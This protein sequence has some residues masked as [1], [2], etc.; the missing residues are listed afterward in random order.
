MKKRSGFAFK[1]KLILL[2]LL[3]LTLPLNGQSLAAGISPQTGR[4]EGT[5]KDETIFVNLSGA[6]GIKEVYVINA[7]PRPNGEIVDFG[8][9]AALVNLTNDLKPQIEGERIT[10]KAGGENGIF[11][12]QGRLIGRKLPWI[13]GFTYYLDGRRL[14]PQDLAG[15]SGRLRMEIGVRANPEADQYFREQFMVQISIP[16]EM[17]K[18]GSIYAPEAV[19]VVAGNLTT[20][21]FTLLPGEEGIFVVEADVERFEMGGIEIAAM[22]AE[23]T[24]GQIGRDLESG[25]ADMAEGMEELIEGTE[26]LQEGMVDFSDGAGRLYGAVA[27]INENSPALLAGIGSFETGLTDLATGLQELKAGFDGFRSV[28][29][30][31]AAMLEKEKKEKLK[32]LSQYL[33]E[34]PDP[35]VQELAD[36][37]LAQIA[38]LEEIQAGIEGSNGGL[39]ALE[40]TVTGAEGLLGSFT[41]LSTGLR[42]LLTGMGGISEGAGTMSESAAVLPA[43]VQKLIDGQKEM[44]EGIIEAKGEIDEL[45]EGEEAQ[46]V[47]F[48]SPGRANA[49]SVQFVMRTPPVKIPEQPISPDGYQEADKNVWQRFQDLF[50]GRFTLS[51]D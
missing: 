49:Q 11:R 45:T 8:D 39:A 47:S 6:G 34:N 19:R 16:L 41:G 33:L 29:I 13:F 7:F 48:V 30:G 36:A 38:A 46:T 50:R 27:K 51:R 40:K 12:Y 35:E 24:L 18:S 17:D 4:S 5:L 9:Y 25:F 1:V 15:A 26:K 14:K 42:E 3:M 43:E 2:S 44:R 21:A 20:L 28:E 32:S 31:I 22:R 10:F 37:M 23:I